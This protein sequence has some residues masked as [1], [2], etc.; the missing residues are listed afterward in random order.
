MGKR[1][2]ETKHT[3]RKLRSR[4]IDGNKLS[5]DYFSLFIL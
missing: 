4:K 3:A 5:I 1:E 2:K